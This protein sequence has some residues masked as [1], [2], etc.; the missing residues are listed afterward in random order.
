[1]VPYVRTAII[2]F[3]QIFLLTGTAGFLRI[4]FFTLPRFY[5]NKGPLGIWSVNS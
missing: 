2:P 3:V 4:F 1:M 5:V